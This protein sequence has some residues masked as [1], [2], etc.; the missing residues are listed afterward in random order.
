MTGSYT[1]SEIVTA[2]YRTILLREPDPVGL[3]HTSNQLEQHGSIEQII[4]S[5]LN[6]PEF[7]ERL[8]LFLDRY[9]LDAAPEG[10]LPKFVGGHAG[11]L[12]G[13]EAIHAIIA[14]RHSWRGVDVLGEAGNPIDPL[15]N[16]SIYRC[17]LEENRAALERRGVRIHGL[18]ADA[19]LIIVFDE[20]AKPV[21]VDIFAYGNSDNI[22]VFGSH[23]RMQGDIRIGGHGNLAYCGGRE[24]LEQFYRVAFYSS[25]STFVF[26]AGSTSVGTYF[27]LE[28]PSRYLV[29]GRDCMFSAETYVATTD[30][31]AILEDE[32]GKIINLPED[33]LIGEHAWIGFGATILKGAHVGRNAIVAARAVLAKPAPPG[34]LVAGTPAKVVREGVTWR[35]DLPSTLQAQRDLADIS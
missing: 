4:I 17:S 10:S 3:L 35:R 20:L 19:E 16:P 12:D 18:G 22:V 15:S 7:R 2:A 24:T 13:P 28:G 25:A 23:C 34:T 32:S 5:A 33:L 30:N 27:H 21:S 8:A 6:S 11:E 14:G 9:H 1:A 29:V 31:H 26:G